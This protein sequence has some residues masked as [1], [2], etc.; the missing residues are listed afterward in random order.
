MKATQLIPK[1]YFQLW[2]DM[3]KNSGGRLLAN[4]QIG[5]D[6]YVYYQFDDIQ[7]ANEFEQEYYRLITPIIET[8]RTIWKR[9][10]LAIGLS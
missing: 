7:K 3:F 2:Y 6:V 5:K 1:Q 8:R 9:I 4:P 10:K